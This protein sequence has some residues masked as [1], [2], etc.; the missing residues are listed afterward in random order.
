VVSVALEADPVVRLV[1]L[2]KV[3]GSTRGI[4]RVDLE[5]QAGQVFGFLGPN[6]A[7]KST[8][9]RLMMGLYLPTAG[10]A[11]LFGIDVRAHGPDVRRRIGYLPGELALYPGLSGREILDRTAHLRGGV[12]PERRSR[13]V[14]R[15]GAELHRPVHLLSKGNRQKIGLIAAFMHDPDLLV[16]D[17]PTSGLDPLLQREFAGL[18]EEAVAGGCTVFLSSH[19]LAEVQRLAHRVAIIRDGRIVALDT[20]D[21]LRARSPRSIELTFRDVVDPAWFHTK[22]GIDLVS[23]SARRATFRVVGEVGPLFEAAVTHGLV[24]VSS[25]EADLDELFLAYYGDAVGAPRDAG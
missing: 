25:Q 11:D 22:A 17:E 3:F 9:I 6:G 13:L 23:V 15:F 24:D 16:L 4:S 19:D 20:V 18:L 12:D 5:V 10:R 14:E 1:S 7:G 21:A 8:T 2:T